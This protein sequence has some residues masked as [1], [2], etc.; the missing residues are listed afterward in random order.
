MKLKCHW[1]PNH[2]LKVSKRWKDMN[3]YQVRCSCGELYAMHDLLKLISLWDSEFERMY[4]NQ[5]VIYNA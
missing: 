1:L 2:K 3:G 4:K 5:E